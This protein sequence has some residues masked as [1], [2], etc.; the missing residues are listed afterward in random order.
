MHSWPIAWNQA[1]DRPRLDAAF[2]ALA[3]QSRRWPSP[4]DLRL[5][6]PSRQYPQP[7]LPAADYPPEKAKENL[8]RIKGLIREAFK[9]TDF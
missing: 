5:L 6:L 9:F 4:A 2:L 8:Q 1:L 3:S 7:A